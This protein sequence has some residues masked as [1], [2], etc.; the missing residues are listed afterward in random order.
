[1]GWKA[2]A[3]AVSINPMKTGQPLGGVLALQGFYRAMPLLHGAQGCSAFIK[4]LMTRHFREPIASQTTALHE[5]NVI[6]GGGQC[7]R[8]GLDTIL[9]KH[10]PSFIGVLSTALTEVSGE[11]IEGELR[12]YRKEK[13]LKDTLLVGVS[14]P[15][16]RGSLESGYAKTTEAVIQG[17]LELG[18]DERT[19][20]KSKNRINLLAG[21]HLTPGDVMELKEI[22]SSFG[23]EVIVLPDLSTSLSGHLLT[24][25]T[26]LTRGGLPL[27]YARHVL[28]AESTLAVG[29]SM[30]PAAKL[31][32][33]QA[34]IPYK[35]F[36]S[37][38]GLQASDQL[39]AYLAARSRQ[40]VPVRY[41]WQREFLLDS[42]L[43]AHFVFGG[44][45]AAVALEPDHLYSVA[46][47]LREMGAL[48]AALVSSAPSPVFDRMEEQVWIGDW[49]DL[50]ELSEKNGADVWIGSSHGE[51]GAERLGVPFY[52][53]G[54]PVFDRFGSSLAVGIGYRGTT[55]WINGMGN[56]LLAGERR[57]F[58]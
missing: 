3:K 36:P 4:A 57:K 45:K 31:L 22:V 58:A 16:F 10:K 27:D 42:M 39:F 37:L 56:I 43:D 21:S 55:E 2:E 24:G 25:H 17:I 5:F 34:G 51:Q 18:R 20:K 29:E 50:E 6:F 44:K 52:P 23:F 40:E 33:Q 13:A 38:L 35:V 15:D 11:D 53:C 12:A 54:F 46:G 47:W 41:R 9:E 7:L 14:L 48:P 28:T 19:R 26:P 49:G 30:V 1:M 32:E 8:E